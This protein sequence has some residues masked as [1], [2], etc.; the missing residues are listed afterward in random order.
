MKMREMIR[1]RV[2]VHVDMHNYPVSNVFYCPYSWTM[3]PLYL[4]GRRSG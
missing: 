1:L 4:T 3:K 2:S